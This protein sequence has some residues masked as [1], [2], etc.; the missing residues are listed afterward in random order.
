[1]F[2][3]IYCNNEWK[4]NKKTSRRPCVYKDAGD[5]FSEVIPAST[6]HQERGTSITVQCRGFHKKSRLLLEQKHRQLI[7]TIWIEKVCKCPEHIVN[8]IL[9]WEQEH[10][11]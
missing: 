3:G 8:R 9:Q 1:M 6:R 11:L 7:P 4:G 2:I 10:T 5:G